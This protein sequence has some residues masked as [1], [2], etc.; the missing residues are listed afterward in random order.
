MT[1]ASP[2]DRR[3]VE[4]L[5]ERARRWRSDREG[6]RR[7]EMDLI[8]LAQG[9]SRDAEGEILVSHRPQVCGLCYRLR[10]R[11]MDLDDYVQEGLAAMLLPIQRFDTA[12]GLPLWLYARPFVRHV[13]VRRLGAWV[14]LTSWQAERY[15]GVWAA[16]DALDAEGTEPTPQ[17]I[18]A[19]FRAPGRKNVGEATVSAIL[20]A[21]RQRSLTLDEQRDTPVVGESTASSAGWDSCPS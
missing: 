19:Y 16:H 5:G 21:G 14:G 2:A 8:E 20:A 10:V 7:A 11:S 12:R 18:S 15:R 4:A 9:G 1:P 6:S 13:L 3:H 17:A